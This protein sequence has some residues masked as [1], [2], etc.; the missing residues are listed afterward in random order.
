[1]TEK[2]AA[3]WRDAFLQRCEN[4]I[5]VYDFPPYEEF[6]E[7]L[8]REFRDVDSKADAL[9]KLNT[10][11]QGNN[12]IEAHNAKFR[13]LVNESDLDVEENDTVLTNYYQRSLND[14]I[15][16]AVWKL[17]PIPANLPQWMAA[18]QNEDNQMKQ[19]ARFRKLPNAT[20]TES[21][22][23][24][25]FSS[26]LKKKPRT[27]KTI[28]NTEVDECDDYDDDEEEEETEFDH[29]ELDLCVAGSD[30][31]ACFNCGELGHFS[32]E[33]K[34]P[35]K[36]PLGPKSPRVSK[37]TKFKKAEAITKNLRN[38]TTD[39]RELLAEM[40]EEEGF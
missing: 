27:G 1:M 31:G 19:F 10:I 2:V 40:L 20:P 8:K 36:K 23:R 13:L 18:A 24:R 9:Y 38:L 21:P 6:I 14:H 29:S 17:R 25:F 34:K 35:R 33:C 16:A 12:P 39:E 4:E 3:T 32:R 26:Y 5:G 15:L 11:S 22:K 28:R 37:F 7:G 30:K